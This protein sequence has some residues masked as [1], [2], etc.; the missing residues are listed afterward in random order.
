MHLTH[1]CLH[2]IWHSGYRGNILYIMCSRLVRWTPISALM[3]M[4]RN[5]LCILVYHVYQGLKRWDCWGPWS[6]SYDWSILLIRIC[7]SWDVTGLIQLHWDVL[8]LWRC[9][10]I[11]V[12]TLLSQCHEHSST[13]TFIGLRK[14]CLLRLSRC[15]WS[16]SLLHAFYLFM[17]LHSS[18]RYEVFRWNNLSAVWDNV[19]TEYCKC[20]LLLTIFTK[21]GNILILIFFFDK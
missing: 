12:F 10:L 14:A 19:A 21:S 9:E 8:S 15:L 7:S 4:G 11:P 18:N 16:F 17:L 20:K 3:E 6:K 5:K 13:H 1:D 2:D